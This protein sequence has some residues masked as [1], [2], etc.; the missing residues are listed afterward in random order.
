MRAGVALVL[1]LELAARL[2]APPPSMPPGAPFL[3]ADRF[4]GFVLSQSPNG[5][6]DVTS[7]GYK[8][9]RDWPAPAREG[10][11]RIMVIGDSNSVRL[12]DV[13]WPGV[14]EDRLASGPVTRRVFIANV[15]VPGWST[16]NAAR[17]A[18]REIPSFHPDI[19]IVAVGTNDPYPSALPDA[20]TCGR[21]DV[22]NRAVLLAE[23]TSRLLEHLF[24]GTRWRRTPPV[25]TEPRLTPQE[26]AL[27]I[28]TILNVDPRPRRILILPHYPREHFGVHLSSDD[29]ESYR[30]A[31]RAVGRAHGVH[32]LDLTP[33]LDGPGR[34]EF[35][36]RGDE[37]HLNRS[38]ARMIAERVAEF[39]RADPPPREPTGRR[40]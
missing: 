16:W 15:S 26:T 6:Y 10:E 13:D 37:I 4:C 14:L 1:A 33:Q 31:I 2:F 28:A 29:A 25:G 34:E 9:T 3:V 40:P 12:D 35:L 32:T 36:T 24:S 11:L 22:H 30:E 18:T 38:G 17:A 20:V 27:N 8:G 19:L 5:E 39:I 23:R 7:R 21:P